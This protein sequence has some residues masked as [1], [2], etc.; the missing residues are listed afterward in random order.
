MKNK[1]QMTMSPILWFIYLSIL[2][3]IIS[4]IL[5]EYSD[6]NKKLTKFEESFDTFNNMLK[7]FPEISRKADRAKFD[8]IMLAMKDIQDRL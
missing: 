4:L 5:P 6:I 3:F 7:K 8:K 2:V 1:K